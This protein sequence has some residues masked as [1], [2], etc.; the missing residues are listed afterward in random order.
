MLG[1]INSLVFSLDLSIIVLILDGVILDGSTLFV[2]TT[3]FGAL[4]AVV[5]VVI[6]RRSGGLGT[7]LGSGFFGGTTLAVGGSA[8]ILSLELLKMLA[9]SQV[10]QIE[11]V[12]VKSL[13]SEAVK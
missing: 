7:L 9:K 3:L 2:S 11:R 10:S 12:R 13:R 4:L 1:R 8:A 6:I 5:I